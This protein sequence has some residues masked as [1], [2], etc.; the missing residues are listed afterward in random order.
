M[1]ACLRSGWSQVRRW[2]RSH[3]HSCRSL[4]GA[5]GRDGGEKGRTW[6]GGREDRR[7]GRKN[8]KEV[9]P[10]T[11]ATGL[12]SKASRVVVVGVEEVVWGRKGWTTFSP[13]W[14][15]ESEKRRQYGS[16]SVLRSY[17]LR[18]PSTVN[19]PVDRFRS[20]WSLAAMV[21]NHADCTLDVE[22]MVTATSAFAFSAP[23]LISVQTARPCLW[24]LFCGFP[25]LERSFAAAWTKTAAITPRPIYFQIRGRWLMIKYPPDKIFST[26]APAP[27]ERKR[28]RTACGLQQHS[29][30][31]SPSDRVPC[32]PQSDRE[33]KP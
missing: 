24:H 11:W 26:R 8:K 4:G 15:P 1:A 14:P 5:S 9:K 13:R 2:W 18:V 31:P 7:K 22:C 6:Q 23:L 29:G 17:F 10:R 30:S 32:F 33:R 3:W 21:N 25:T 12:R 27:I 16:V 19:K 20:G 28:D